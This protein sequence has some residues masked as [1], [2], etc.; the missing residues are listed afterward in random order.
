M[1]SDRIK[2]R[3]NLIQRNVIAT[4]TTLKTA[5]HRIITNRRTYYSNIYVA[6]RRPNYMKLYCA[7]FAKK[8][9]QHDDSDHIFWHIC[10]HT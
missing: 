10:F 7:N 2:V 6:L 9:M 1:N 4:N 8:I 3:L 5:K